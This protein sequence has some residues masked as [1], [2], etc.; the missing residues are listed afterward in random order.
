MYMV[1]D[2]LAGGLNAVSPNRQTMKGPL[3]GSEG[4]W[5]RSLLGVL[6]PHTAQC[7]LSSNRTRR[8]RS[9]STIDGCPYRWPSYSASSNRRRNS[10]PSGR[11]SASCK[12]VS[13]CDDRV[14][15]RIHRGS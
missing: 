3:P 4:A 6:Y 5:A 9:A 13:A 14:D 10:V 1:D 7:D 8:T 12:T 2:G 15:D 11:R